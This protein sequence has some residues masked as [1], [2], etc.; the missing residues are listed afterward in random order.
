MLEFGQYEVPNAFKTINQVNLNANDDNR[1]RKM[2][3][4]REND[5]LYFGGPLSSSGIDKNTPKPLYRFTNRGEAS[6]K[7]PKSQPKRLHPVETNRPGHVGNLSNVD[8]EGSKSKPKDVIPNPRGTNPLEPQYKLQSFTPEPVFEPRFLRDNI[9]NADI[10]G[11]QVKVKRVQLATRDII[12]V[13]DIE[14]TTTTWRPHH[15]QNFGK[16]EARTAPLDISDINNRRKPFVS[17][18]PLNLETASIKGAAPKP[19]PVRT[20]DLKDFSIRTDDVEGSRPSRKRD[21]DPFKFARRPG[22]YRDICQTGDIE[23]ARSKEGVR[24]EVG[25]KTRSEAR[26]Q[27]F[28]TL[29]SDYDRAQAF[30]ASGVGASLAENGNTI[31]DLTVSLRKQDREESGRLTKDELK[32][33]LTSMQVDISSEQAGALVDS[34]DVD[35]SGYMNYKEFVKHAFRFK[36]G[37]VTPAPA[38]KK[39]EAEIAAEAAAKAEAEAKA[40]KLQ[41]KP[42]KPPPPPP[43]IMRRA[44]L[45]QG[46]KRVFA[47]KDAS[48]AKDVMKDSSGSGKTVAWKPSN[49]RKMVPQSK[50]VLGIS[51]QELTALRRSTTPGEGAGMGG[52]GAPGASPG[53][54]SPAVGIEVQMLT[55]SFSRPISAPPGAGLVQTRRQI[56]ERNDD[57]AAVR[58]LE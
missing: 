20:G 10:D 32:S 46:G 54:G 24:P 47:G 44:V 23:G 12:T 56:K 14:G 43:P 37:I 28:S 53:F 55:E 26:Q 41:A 7:D 39:T 38:P 36:K 16:G 40:E 15:R 57:I 48:E 19:Q 31:K 50:P 6:E 13:S 49:D 22:H 18:T 3:Q 34:F 45:R 5:P 17:E 35:K 2:G 9:S 4:R 25:R 29:S 51:T 33:A 11:S 52:M 58:S 21:N 1:G 30:V 27:V 42:G 8:I